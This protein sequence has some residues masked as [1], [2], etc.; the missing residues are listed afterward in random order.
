MNRF[1]NKAFN[2]LFKNGNLDFKRAGFESQ[3]NGQWRKIVREDERLIILVDTRHQ[4]ITIRF[5]DKTLSQ[6]LE[7]EIS[8]RD[9]KARLANYSGNRQ[10]LYDFGLR[11]KW[12]I[13]WVMDQ[14]GSRMTRRLVIT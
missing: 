4:L 1:L 13:G 2:N 5:T 7:I 3:D 11:H 6:L 8:F 9:N 12:L 14:I 10:V